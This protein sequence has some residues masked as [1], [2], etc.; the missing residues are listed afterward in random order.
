MQ[1][2]GYVFTEHGAPM[3]ASVLNTSKAIEKR[4]VFILDMYNGIHYNLKYL[5][6][7]HGGY[8]G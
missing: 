4:I 3:V 8:K 2:P 1:H 5:S 6:V 7:I